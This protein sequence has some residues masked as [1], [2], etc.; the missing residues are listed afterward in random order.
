VNGIC[1]SEL[2]VLIPNFSPPVKILA[3][4]TVVHTPFSFKSS[5]TWTLSG[6]YSAVCVLVVA[7]WLYHEGW[8]AS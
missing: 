5:E 7:F 2:R 3:Y 8:N 4:V 1:I 6:N